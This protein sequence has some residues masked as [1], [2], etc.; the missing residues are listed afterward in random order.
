MKKQQIME[1]AED[2]LDNNEAPDW[3]ANLMDQFA[4]VYAD[5]TEDGGCLVVLLNNLSGDIEDAYIF[6][7]HEEAEEY[8]YAL[9]AQIFGDEEAF[10]D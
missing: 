9:Q 10:N 8:V 4:S 5:V 2:V 1:L 7:N 3:E 6:K